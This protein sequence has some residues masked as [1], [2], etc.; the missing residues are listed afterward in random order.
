MDELEQFLTAYFGNSTIAEGIDEFSISSSA[1]QS[2]QYA[3]VVM[4]RSKSDLLRA[5]NI[6]ILQIVQDS[7]FSDVANCEEAAQRL[8][9]IASQIERQAAKNSA[10]LGLPSG[11]PV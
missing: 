11:E 3:A 1:D 10:A 9:F 5:G 2:N 8:D 6:G 4:L 7:V